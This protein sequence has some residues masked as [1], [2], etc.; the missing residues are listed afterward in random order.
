M[1]LM[2]EKSLR[3]GICHSIDGYAKASNKY[4]KDFDQNKEL[5]FISSIL[6]YN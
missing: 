1:L 2:V 6:G 3:E 4:M 5:S